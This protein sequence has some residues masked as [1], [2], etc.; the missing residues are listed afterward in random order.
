MELACREA[1][2]AIDQPVTSHSEIIKGDFLF[3][4]YPLSVLNFL[5]MIDQDINEKEGMP[6]MLVCHVKQANYT[7]FC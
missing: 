7:N 4:K 6:P 3:G 2:C 5:A 1:K